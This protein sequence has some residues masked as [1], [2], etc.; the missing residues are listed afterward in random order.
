ML[1]RLLIVTDQTQTTKNLDEHF[2]D[3]HADAFGFGYGTGEAHIMPVVKKFLELCRYRDGID[4]GYS[5]PAYDFRELEKELT[6]P[7]AW[8][9][10][11]CMPIEYGTSPR[12]GWL[13]VGGRA[14]KRFF[15]N[16]TEDELYELATRKAEDYCECY[17]DLCCCGPSGEQEGRRCPNPFWAD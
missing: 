11:N 13:D 2:Y 5:S 6:P 10:I 17:P 1:E 12:F 4:D 7:V 15:D 14:L 8:L 3:W 9:L 16:H